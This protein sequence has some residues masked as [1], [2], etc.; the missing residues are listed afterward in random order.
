MASER[1]RRSS[2]GPETNPFVPATNPIVPAQ[3]YWKGHS[4]KQDEELAEQL[5]L[6]KMVRDKT[7]RAK[8]IYLA[9]GSVDERSAREALVRLLSRDDCDDVKVLLCDALRDN[10]K[11]DRRIVFQSRSRGNRSDISS[12]F[13]VALYV[14]R[15]K[16]EGVKVDAAVYYAMMEFGLSRKA[17]FECY[18]RAK[19]RFRDIF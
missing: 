6:G 18:K 10:G 8:R 1:Q 4:R 16:K 5:F 11:G 2:G 19:K 15:F 17:V 9:K 13:T 12:D 14:L 7:G 3:P